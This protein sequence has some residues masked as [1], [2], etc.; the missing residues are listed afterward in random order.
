MTGIDISAAQIA[1]AHEHVPEAT[2]IHADM[3][4]LSFPPNS[5]DAI[6]A[7]YSLFHLPREE[8]SEMIERITGWLKVGGWFLVNLH[9]KEGDNV[10]ENWFNP[11]VT[12]FSSGLGLQGNRDMLKNNGRGLKVV[13]D[14]VA[15]EKVGQAEETF[16]WIFAIKKR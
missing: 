15:V 11:G 16:H 3:M 7:F 13:A 2:L 12:M 1:L 10:R 5:F 4:T 8:Q 6:V 9:T 14:E